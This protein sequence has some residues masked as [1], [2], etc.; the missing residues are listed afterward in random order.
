MATTFKVASPVTQP[1]HVFEW[2]RPGSGAAADDFRVTQ[3]FDDIDYYW[4]DKDPARAALGH[5]AVDIGN[6][7]CGYP[8]VAML[9]GT[10]TLLKDNATAY[11]AATDALGVRI[12]VGNGLTLEYWHLGSWSVANGAR[13]VAG[14]EIGRVGNTGLGAVCH[15]HLEGKIYGTRFDLEPFMP[16]VE[17]AAKPLVVEELIDMELPVDAGYFVSGTVA[18][19]V[20]L[21]VRNDTVEGSTVTEVETPVKVLAILRDKTPYT[22]TV[23]GKAVSDDD[24]YVVMT[25]DGRVWETAKLLVRNIAP[26]GYLFSQVP[27]PKA[28]CSAVEAELAQT[29]LGLKNM[30]ARLS[31][32]NTLANELVV[33][34]KVP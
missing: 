22:I 26:T 7:R 15:C 16:M 5:R 13:V 31:R 29:Q 2:Q 32:A 9:P 25:A 10:V 17:R 11:G 20:R 27:L 12:D 28:D 8:L 4:K 24:W 19:G 3:R 1:L 14:Q 21:R 33:A 34:T 30:T 18:A 6:A 23:D